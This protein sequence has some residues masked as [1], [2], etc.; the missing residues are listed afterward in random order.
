MVIHQTKG[1]LPA[2][3]ERTMVQEM[4]PMGNPGVI[5]H[6]LLHSTL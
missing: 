5:Y 4:V 2:V 6:R 1:F 3:P